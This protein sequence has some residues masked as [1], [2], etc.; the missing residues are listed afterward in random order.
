LGDLQGLAHSV[1][2]ANRP[3]KLVDLTK[4]GL[5]RLGLKKTDLIETGPEAYPFARHWAEQLHAATD[6]DGLCWM[7]RQ[8]DEAHALLLFGDRVK[9][10]AL[11][12]VEPSE[13]LVEPRLRDLIVDIA[14]RI[15]IKKI[16]R[17][18]SEG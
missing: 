18:Q 5:Q 4:K 12:A 6:P 8:D 1:L 13:A 9:A 3:L 11:T 16:V 2:K 17:P 10:K 15:G 7:S 14:E